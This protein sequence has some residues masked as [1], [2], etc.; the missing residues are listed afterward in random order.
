MHIVQVKRKRVDI[1]KD[2]S[3]IEESN[4]PPTKKRK[5]FTPKVLDEEK[6]NQ[7]YECDKCPNPKKFYRKDAYD[8]HLSNVHDD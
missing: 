8:R 6:E 5:L 1:S 3:E 7:V 4:P 2:D